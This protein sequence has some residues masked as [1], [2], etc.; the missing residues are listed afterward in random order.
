[1][2][3]VGAVG[4]DNNR[5]LSVLGQSLIVGATAGTASYLVND[6][7]VFLLSKDAV[8]FAPKASERIENA[9]INSKVY[10]N[11]KKNLKHS[12]EELDIIERPIKE[13][14][15]KHRLVSKEIGRRVQPLRDQ[16]A[17][18][19]NPADIAAKREEISNVIK[20]AQEELGAVAGS[21]AVA[22]SV[23]KLSSPE[24]IALKKNIQDIEAGIKNASLKIAKKANRTTALITGAVVTTIL[25]VAA[26]AFDAQKKS[27][28]RYKANHS[29]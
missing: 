4:S 6:Q 14:K 18:L 9:I 7:E 23:K 16:L 27:R 19:V 10:Q 3:R 8:D 28:A 15:A 1:M 22:S 29:G 26:F 20:R 2:V 11:L 5:A 13:I 12:K 21:D 25:A 24:Y 17:A